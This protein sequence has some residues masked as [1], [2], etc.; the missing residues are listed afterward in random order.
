M[1]LYKS[2]ADLVRDLTQE[3]ALC[4][5]GMHITKQPILRFFE[6]WGIA[7]DRFNKEPRLRG[8]ENLIYDKFDEIAS[9]YMPNIIAMNFSYSHML[10]IYNLFAILPPLAN[11]LQKHRETDN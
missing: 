8:I 7:E 1:E 4:I 10:F 5:Y 9:K 3:A 2:N 11:R 6:G